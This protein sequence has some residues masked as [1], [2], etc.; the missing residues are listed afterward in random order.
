LTLVKMPEC[1]GQVLTQIKGYGPKKRSLANGGCSAGRGSM[2]LS[3]A[4]SALG[5]G[6]AQV[7]LVPDRHG[8]PWT[9]FPKA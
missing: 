4:A 3:H 9:G 5:S 7:I 2:E 6:G 8:S 1:A